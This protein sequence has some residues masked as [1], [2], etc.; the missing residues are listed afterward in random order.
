MPSTRRQKNNKPHRQSG[1]GLIE[2]LIVVA[3]MAIATIAI[4]TK[5]NKS[6]QVQFANVIYK[7]QGSSQRAVHEHVQDSD[8]SK[9]DFSNFMNDGATSGV[10]NGLHP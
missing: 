9:K 7:I 8:V 1:Q 6:V 10:T 2:Y 4:V 5:L 3:L